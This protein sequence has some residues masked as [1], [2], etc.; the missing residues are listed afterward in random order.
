MVQTDQLYKKVADLTAGIKQEFRAKGIVLPTRTNRG[1]K[2]DNYS[3]VKNDDDYYSILTST[4]EVVFDKINLSY[5]AI[6]IANTLALGQTVDP[7]LIENDRQHGYQTFEEDNY[8]RM[9]AVH[10]KKK[11][12]DRAET[13]LLKQKIAHERA[14]IAKKYI[15]ASFEKLRRLR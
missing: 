5:T 15:V 11:D 7:K 4:D 8:R 14:K 2:L 1:I 12:W 10:T 13:A 9:V 6:V 3:V